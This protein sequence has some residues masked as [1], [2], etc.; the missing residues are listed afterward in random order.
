MNKLLVY[1]NS[2]SGERQISFASSCGTTIGYL[3][4]AISAQQT[5][6]VTICVAI[7]RESLNAVTRKDLRPTDWAANW[8][9]LPV[10]D[11]VHGETEGSSQDQQQSD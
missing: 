1:L 5:L 11:C 7:E 2:L 9:E 6:G 10:E 8:P 3:R 4:K